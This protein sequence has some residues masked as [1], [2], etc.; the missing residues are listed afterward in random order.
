METSKFW[1]ITAAN[2]RENI[3]N[4]NKGLESLTQREL[5]S[6]LI[7]NIYLKIGEQLKQGI[8]RII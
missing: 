5:S 8:D 3:S 2:W 7:R 1:K 6:N 4:I